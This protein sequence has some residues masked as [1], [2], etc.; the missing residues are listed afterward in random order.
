M[1]VEMAL[2]LT[3]G[4]RGLASPRQRVPHARLLES[5]APSWGKERGIS[6]HLHHVS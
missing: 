1:K 6:L 2:L 5:T 3:A 4:R